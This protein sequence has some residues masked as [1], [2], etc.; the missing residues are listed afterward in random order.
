[1]SGA[2]IYKHPLVLADSQTIE[3]H[4]GSAILDVQVQRDSICLW[5]MEDLFAHRV[6]RTIFIVG[7][8][9]PIDHDLGAH[10][11]TVQVGSF[12]WHVFDGGER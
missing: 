2:V 7:T 12:V 3:V 1:M 8:G 11:G 6:L 9:N 5:V 4:Y 10:I